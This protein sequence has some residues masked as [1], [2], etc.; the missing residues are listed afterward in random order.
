M[1]EFLKFSVELVLL[2]LSYH[3]HRGSIPENELEEQFSIIKESY[4]Q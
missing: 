4:P 3:K 1:D 2:N